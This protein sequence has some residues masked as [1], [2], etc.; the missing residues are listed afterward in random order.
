MSLLTDSAVLEA[1]FHTPVLDT[2]V[3]GSAIL[4]NVASR[5]R[6][7]LIRIEQDRDGV[8]AETRWRQWS[9]ISPTRREW[10]VAV[11]H[12]SE[13][14][15]AVW[16]QWSPEQ[17]QHAATCL[18]SPFQADDAILNEFLRT[19]DDRLKMLGAELTS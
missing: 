4:A 5:M 12:A 1:K 8:A 11:E 14:W 10:S 19:V 18:L 7:A 17:R 6:D 2:D 16:H 9:A 3:P 13:M 15:R